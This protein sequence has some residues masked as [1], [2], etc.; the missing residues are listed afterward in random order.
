MKFADW[1]F[2]FWKNEQISFPYAYYKRDKWEKI[3]KKKKLKVD[4]IRSLDEFPSLPIG[5]TYLFSILKK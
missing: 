2:N 3:I 5:N 1:V 4:A